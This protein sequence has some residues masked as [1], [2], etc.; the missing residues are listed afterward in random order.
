M[1]SSVGLPDH[2]HLGMGIHATRAEHT[3]LYGRRLTKPAVI[4]EPGSAALRRVLPRAQLST[5]FRFR[6]ISRAARPS[7]CNRL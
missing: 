6:R 4:P 2:L 3:D 5:D 1:D 7:G